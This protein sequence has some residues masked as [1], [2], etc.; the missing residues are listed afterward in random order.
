MLKRIELGSQVKTKKTIVI[1][2]KKIK[3][4]LVLVDNI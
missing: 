1:I 4:I 3:Q 2:N